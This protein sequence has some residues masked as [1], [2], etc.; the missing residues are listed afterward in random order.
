M[1][2]GHHCS[3]PSMK[4][5]PGQPSAC[6]IAEQQSAPLEA[7]TLG[8][9]DRLA[10]LVRADDSV[11]R[12]AVIGGNKNSVAWLLQ[13]GAAAGAVDQEGRRPLL[14]ASMPGRLQIVPL[15][16][17]AG[18]DPKAADPKGWTTRLPRREAKRTSWIARAARLCTSP[19]AVAST[20]RRK[21]SLM[22]ARK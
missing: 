22:R 9:A 12:W 1:L 11:L 14:W 19:P 13:H 16:L 4:S 17:E 20:W 10:Q 8:R 3:R 18:A 6:W 21:R 7:A 2:I 15:L 5:A